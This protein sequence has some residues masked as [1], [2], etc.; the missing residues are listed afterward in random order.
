MNENSG[1]EHKNVVVN[2]NSGISRQKMLRNPVEEASISKA[3]A[4]ERTGRTATE[5]AMM[6]AE[7]PDR[8]VR[9]KQLTFIPPF[10]W[11]RDAWL[12]ACGVDAFS[13]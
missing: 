6:L 7:S 3:A 2:V 13:D 1:K 8:Q 5:S 11:M 10:I 9:R 12:K 4:S